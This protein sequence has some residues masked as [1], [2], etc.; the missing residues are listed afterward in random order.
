MSTM[1]KPGGMRDRSND[2]PKQAKYD[3]AT[4][5]VGAM[6]GAGIE[7]YNACKYAGMR[8]GQ[9]NVKLRRSVPEP[10]GRLVVGRD[11]NW[12]INKAYSG[13]PL[14]AE[15]MAAV[16]AEHPDWKAAADEYVGF[17]V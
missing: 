6:D 4:I 2:P 8:C 14:S 1:G 5:D 7:V 3:G 12:L 13:A 16:E 9:Y 15:E 10:M 17:Y 11:R